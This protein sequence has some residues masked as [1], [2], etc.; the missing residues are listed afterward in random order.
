VN[1]FAGRRGVRASARLVAII[2]M[3]AVLGGAVAAAC[4]GGSGSGA[5]ATPFATVDGIPCQNSEQLVY[6]V[7]SH[8]TLI[9]ENQVVQV[10]AGVGINDNTCLFWLH[11][12]DSSGVIHVEAPSQRQ[13]TLGQFFDIWGQPLSASNLL[14]HETDAT[15]QIHAYVNQQ[16]YTGN[17]ADIQ[18]GAHADIVLEYGPPFP[19]LPP[20]YV[21]PPGL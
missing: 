3:L 11:T 14:G 21:F 20:P 10:P 17:P 5:T 7:H 2:G 1:V 9:V 4:G 13:F 6:H 15:H 18:L 12:H 8:L 16:P 19:E